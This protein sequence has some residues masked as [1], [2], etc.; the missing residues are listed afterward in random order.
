MTQRAIVMLNLVQHLKVKDVDF[1]F[2]QLRQVENDKTIQKKGFQLGSLFLYYEIPAFAGIG[3][4]FQPSL[5]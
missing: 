1:R 3:L 5:S 4:P 2:V